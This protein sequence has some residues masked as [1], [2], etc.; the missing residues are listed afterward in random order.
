MYVGYVVLMKYNERLRD[1]CQNKFKKDQGYKV[2]PDGNDGPAPLARPGDAGTGG[3][4]GEPVGSGETKKVD[5]RAPIPNPKGRRLST[6]FR[7]GVLNVLMDEKHADEDA[8]RVHAVSAMEGDVHDT[9]NRFDKDKSGFI[10]KSELENV[11]KELFSGGFH[12]GKVDPT[13]LD[14][15]M[16]QLVSVRFNTCGSLLCALQPTS[17]T[18]ST[19]HS[20]LDTAVAKFDSESRQ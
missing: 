4:A 13:L 18:N 7:A 19:Q 11:F 5:T 1:W 16:K 12:G 20:K 2:S 17:V 8:L 14:N 3:T 9:F 15:A 6:M 10:D